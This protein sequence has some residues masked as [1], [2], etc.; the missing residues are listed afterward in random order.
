MAYARG[1]ALSVAGDRAAA[2]EFCTAIELGSGV[3][4]RHVVSLSR[5]FLAIEYTRTGDYELA[6]D[7][8]A[9]AVHDFRR[10]GNYTDA[11]TTIR[12]LVEL[13]AGVGD[14]RGATVLGAVTAD[15]NSPSAGSGTGF[16]GRIDRLLGDVRR[17]VGRSR[18]ETWSEEGRALPLDDA[19]RA[20]A[21][22]VE[23]QRH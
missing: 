3:G 4:S 9:S 15:Y 13:L 10:H 21:A 18:F 11:T 20:A 1:D 23:A 6:F 22:F 16:G 7:A 12:G 5:T 14:D 2:E 19:L 17:R 8:Y